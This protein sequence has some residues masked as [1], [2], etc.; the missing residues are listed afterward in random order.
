MY[1]WKIFYTKGDSQKLKN[2]LRQEREG[3][4]QIIKERCLK[5]SKK[6]ETCEVLSR[7]AESRK[8]S[9]LIKEIWENVEAE[10]AGD[11]K[12]VIKHTYKV[13]KC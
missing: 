6:C 11:G 7:R 5:H 1:Y 4:A 2:F 3:T 9:A 10:E 8:E 13:L 12:Y